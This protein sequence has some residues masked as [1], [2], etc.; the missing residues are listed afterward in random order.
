VTLGLPTQFPTLTTFTA[1]PSLHLDRTTLDIRPTGESEPVVRLSK[2]GSLRRRL[3]YEVFTGPQLQV[4]AGQ[5]TAGGAL[6]TDGTP[7]GIVN[8]T[9]GRIPDHDLHPLKGGPV[10]A[11]HDN[12]AKWRVVQPGLPA[13]TGARQGM[14]TWVRFNP[15]T[16]FLERQ[17]LYLWYLGLFAPMRFR[18][19]GPGSPGFTVGLRPTPAR[20]DVT[21][22]DPRID[23]RL[24]FASVA[25]LA[26]LVMT[27]PQSEVVD[28]VALFRRRK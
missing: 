28:T 4:P 3:A 15:V 11:I 2:P 9:G 25:A 27:N 12:P 1:K 24:T 7:L 26:Q 23:P 18:Y 6:D 10:S 14:S 16:A 8:L 21:I 13:L 20:F 5:V 17:G 19:R 22:H